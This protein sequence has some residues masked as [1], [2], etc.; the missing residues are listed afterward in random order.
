MK[1]VAVQFYGMKGTKGARPCIRCGYIT[2]SWCE[3]CSLRGAVGC[4]DGSVRLHG[5]LWQLRESESSLDPGHQHH[6]EKPYIVGTWWYTWL[7]YSPKDF[8][9]VP[10][11]TGGETSKMFCNVVVAR[12]LGIENHQKSSM[13]FTAK[14]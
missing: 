8:P 6:P 13:F 11:H 14:R 1:V 10:F 9:H 4:P 5:R 2:A 12:S 3:G 7:M